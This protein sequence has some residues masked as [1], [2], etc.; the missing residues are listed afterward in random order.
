[1]TIDRRWCQISTD[2]QPHRHKIRHNRYSLTSRRRLQI[3]PPLPGR[4][5]DPQ[6]TPTGTPTGGPRRPKPRSGRRGR[7]PPARRRD[8]HRRSGSTPPQS[9]RST[10]RTARF[11]IG[12]GAQRRPGSRGSEDRKTYS[13]RWRTR[14][15]MFVR[16][17]D[18]CASSGSRR[19]ACRG[20]RQ[21]RPVPR[22]SPRR[23]PAN[24]CSS[25]RRRCTETKVPIHTTDRERFRVE[26]AA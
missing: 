13:R 9:Q 21:W 15:A 1:M 5:L 25:S 6:L 17:R 20:I 10:P 7:S 18:G 19:S 12:G 11:G 3:G 26:R 8:T 2:A 4:T 24:R 23:S 14:S 16:V 22:R